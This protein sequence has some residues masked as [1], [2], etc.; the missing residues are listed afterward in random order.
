M[1]VDACV[2]VDACAGADGGDVE[3]EFRRGPTVLRKVSDRFGRVSD[4]LRES[5]T[6]VYVD[7]RKHS[8]ELF[9]C[10]ARVV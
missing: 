7:A 9:L 5:A 10:C 2:G 6:R 1:G 3:K 4:L 8:L